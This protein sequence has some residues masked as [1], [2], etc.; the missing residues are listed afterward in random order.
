MNNN[1][2]VEK[3]RALRFTGMANAFEVALASRQ[4]QK[5]T[6]D[7][8]MAYLIEQEW[9]YRQ[10]KHIQSLVMRAKF[11]YTATIEELQFAG[12][13]NLDKNNVLRL[14]SGNYLESKENIIITGST[15]VG[16]SFLAS[17]IGHQA[18]VM[19]YKVLYFNTVKLFQHLKMS[20]AD[21]TYMKEIKRIEKADLLIL[22]D[23][24]L[25]PLDHPTRIALLEIIEDRH[26]KSSTMITSQIPVANWYELFEEK[27]I[28]DAILDRIVHSSQRL[29]LKGESLRKK[30]STNKIV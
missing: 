2:T 13:R 18:C 30:Q 9:E 3:M 22:D 1:A 24:G 20:K 8:L 6:P 28:A 14:A 15:G 27:T 5:Y 17:A 11:R 10:N 25:Q 19:G 12:T 4:H 29:E 21:A 26:G 16:K 23:F 7:E